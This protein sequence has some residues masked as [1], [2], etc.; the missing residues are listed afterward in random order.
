MNEDGTC[1]TCYN[2][3]RV[4]DGICKV[5][6]NCLRTDSSGNCT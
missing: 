4:V 6:N 5:I 1:L 3:E 2:K